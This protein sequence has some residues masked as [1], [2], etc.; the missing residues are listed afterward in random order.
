MLQ[1]DNIL[2]IDIDGTICTIDQDYTKCKLMPG[3]KNAIKIFRKKGYK[4]YLY[5]GRH[6][7]HAELT[8][9][10]LKKNKVFFDHIIFG[11]PPAKYYIDDRSLTFKSWKN[12]L[13]IIK[14]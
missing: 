2:A 12:V 4:I 14:L 3:C 5:T 1:S 8:F 13:K 10:W 7:N 9:K 6:I 11:K